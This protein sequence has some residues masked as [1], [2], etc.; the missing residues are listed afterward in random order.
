MPCSACSSENQEKFVG[1]NRHLPADFGIWSGRQARI[2]TYDSA[3]HAAR[4]LMLLLL[5]LSQ[6]FAEDPAVQ[7]RRDETISRADKAF[8]QRYTPVT[9]K[10]MRLHDTNTE[11]G[12]ADAVIFW[13]CSSHI[14]MLIFAADGTIARIVLQPEVLLHS[15]SWT[16]VPNWVELSPAE[17]EWLTASANTLRPLGEAH[18]INHNAPNGCFRSGK[19]LFCVDRYE[20]AAVSHYHIEQ[21]NEQKLLKIQLKDIAIAY[22]QSVVGTVEDAKVEGSSRHLKVAGQWYYGEEPGS[23][24]FEK[25]EIGSLVRL[26][27]YGCTANEKACIAIPEESNSIAHRQ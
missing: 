25:A 5:L 11:K 10:R 9:G 22:Q 15:D 3:V 14:I 26:V 6:L 17:M 2:S 27:T 16:D 18:E 8:G 4:L 7:R 23:E 13:H 12:P 19:N 21:A 20:H 24:I 1:E